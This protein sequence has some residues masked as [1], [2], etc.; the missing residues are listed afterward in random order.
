MKLFRGVVIK[1][2]Y[3]YYTVTI[4]LNEDE[5]ADS[6]ELAFIR[7]MSTDEALPYTD[8][9]KKNLLKVCSDE[10]VTKMYIML[11]DTNIKTLSI[12]DKDSVD[13]SRDSEMLKPL[14]VIELLQN[15]KLGNIYM[16]IS[17]ARKHFNYEH[18]ALTI[19]TRYRSL[20]IHQRF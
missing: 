15:K 6:K 10:N 5:D 18:D 12:D 8:D 9:F 14:E 13:C 2:D 19:R 17:L 20:P 16:P 11:K 4:L 7:T 3:N 1:T